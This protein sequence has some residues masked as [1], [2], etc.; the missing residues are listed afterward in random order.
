MYDESTTDID[1][2]S[3]LSPSRLSLTLAS[4]SD[5]SRIQLRPPSQRRLYRTGHGGMGKRVSALFSTRSIGMQIC[6]ACTTTGQC[7]MHYSPDQRAHLDSS[8]G[9]QTC[10]AGIKPCCPASRRRDFS[11]RAISSHATGANTRSQ[12]FRRG[13]LLA[14]RLLVL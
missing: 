5:H 11:V 2:F 4:L 14:G 8:G 6:P 13:A 10:K 1:G 9:I 12:N 3:C 7:R